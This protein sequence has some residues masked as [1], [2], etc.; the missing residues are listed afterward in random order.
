MINNVRKM[1][2]LECVNKGDVCVYLDIFYIILNVMKVSIN[3]CKDKY[4]DMFYIFNF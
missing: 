1:N 3:V 2:I 4:I